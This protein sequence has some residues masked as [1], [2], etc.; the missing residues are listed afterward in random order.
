MLKEFKKVLVEPQIWIPYV[1]TGQII[2]YI[3]ILLLRDIFEWRSWHSFNLRDFL[4]VLIW[5]T[6]ISLLSRWMSK[7]FNEFSMEIILLLG[8][9]CKLSLSCNIKVMI[10][11][12]KFLFFV[13]LTSFII[14]L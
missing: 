14:Y 8:I 9:V 13:N 11:F 6:H 4:L 7:Y 1:I 12:H 2:A 10:Y 3:G 5:V